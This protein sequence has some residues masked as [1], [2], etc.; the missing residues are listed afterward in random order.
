M[1][2]VK[3]HID[4]GE[5]LISIKGHAGYA[6]HGK[7]I[8]CAGVSTLVQTMLLGL[9]N[10]SQCYPENVKYIECKNEEEVIYE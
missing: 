8:V 9:E 2:K 1:V 6:E 5:V 7:D 3:T 4:S 10:I